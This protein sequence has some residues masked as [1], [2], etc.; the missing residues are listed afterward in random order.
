MNIKSSTLFRLLFLF[1]AISLIMS[2]AK[3]DNTDYDAKVRFFN[4]VNQASQDFYLNGVKLSTGISYGSNSDYIVTAADKDYN[5]FAKNTGTTVVSDS[6]KSK[7][8]VG[9]NYSVYYYKTSALD[10]VLKVYEDNLTPDTSKSRLFFINLGYTLNSRVMIR[11]ETS[12]FAITLGNGESSGYINIPT[13]VSSKL[14]LNLTDSTSVVDTISYTNFYKG[15]TY[16][17]LIDGV[18]KGA[19]TG[20]LR[21]R[22]IANN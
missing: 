21:E 2:C 15:K 18:S 13:G 6:I 12:S 7:L 14:Y 20:K 8:L 22:L 19:S 4:V 5:I 16:T 17:I 11:N 1:G 10:S 3:S 9:R